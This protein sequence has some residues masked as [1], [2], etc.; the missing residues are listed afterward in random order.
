TQ[1]VF[2]TRQTR[3][4]PKG[5]FFRGAALSPWKKGR[6]KGHMRHGD[7]VGSERGCGL[8]DSLWRARLLFSGMSGAVK[9]N[10]FLSLAG[11]VG[12]GQGCC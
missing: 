5:A 7:Q 12:D 6:K 1:G 8:L 2:T 4:L 9:V 11:G 3:H 10:V